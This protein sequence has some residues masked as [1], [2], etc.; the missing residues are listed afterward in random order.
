MDRIA[1]PLAALMLDALWQSSLCLAVGIAVA[2]AMHRRPAR[3]HSLLLV[4]IVTAVAAP[5]ASAVFRAM[6]WG[7]FEP[8]AHALRDAVPPPAG[9]LAGSASAGLVLPDM[10]I[11][12]LIVWLVVS[13][14]FLARL[15]SSMVLGARLAGNGR[16]LSSPQ[17]RAVARGAADRLGLSVTADLF[18]S[19]RVRCP[20]IW[21]WGRPP[22]VLLPPPERSECGLGDD[23]GLFG[24]LCHE[25]AHFKRSDHLTSLLAEVV[26]C[27]L[28]WNPLA[29]I[30]R[31]RLRSLSEQ[32]CDAWALA[33]G[34]PRVAYAETLLGLARQPATAWAMAAVSGRWSTGRRIA[35]ILQE[36]PGNPKSGARFRVVVVALSVGLV[37][38]AALAQR[39]SAPPGPAPRV[40][41]MVPAR[42]G[43][44]APETPEAAL[45]DAAAQRGVEM[46]PGELDL[47]HVAIGGSRMG[48]MWLVNNGERPRRVESARTS[49]GCATVHNFQPTTL[50]PGESMMIEI[51]MTGPDKAGL[52]KTKYVTFHVEGQVPLR[53]PVH[54]TATDPVE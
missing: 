2:T 30:A 51:T 35:R 49:C 27:L 16:P 54:L 25:L 3:A 33:A 11:V 4:S 15:A 6:G 45:P 32:C 23:D 8:A 52:T 36:G 21:C 42:H 13:A 9:S 28:P 39:R 48:S 31:R 1:D 40:I 38:M 46:M 29:W 44:V 12:L 10:P 18:A 20:V 17:W 53:L 7:L 24:V 37:T 41:T 47:G 19:A 22:R 5:I 43:P 14:A 26:V 34:A 50:Q